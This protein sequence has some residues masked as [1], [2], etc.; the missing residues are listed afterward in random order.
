MKFIGYQNGDAGATAS[1]LLQLADELGIDPRSI[2]TT[3]GGFMVPDELLIVDGVQILDEPPVP[4]LAVPDGGPKQSPEGWYETELPT[5][6]VEMDESTGE[7]FLTTEAFLDELKHGTV[8][9]EP[10][11]EVVRA[12]AKDHGLTVADK[13]ALS[14]AVLSAYAQAHGG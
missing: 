5:P 12:W 7:V 10:D 13:G 3:R 2:R 11:R 1:F 8:V 6:D 9:V 14:K 4:L